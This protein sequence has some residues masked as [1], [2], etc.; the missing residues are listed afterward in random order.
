MLKDEINQNYLKARL[1]ALPHTRGDNNMLFLT[2][3]VLVAVLLSGLIGLSSYTSIANATTNTN[4]VITGDTQKYRIF[5]GQAPTMQPSDAGMATNPMPGTFEWW[6][7][8]GKFNDNST[9][10]ITLLTKP[11]V[12]K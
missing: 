8:Q 2:K 4:H 1:R 11:W 5:E 12:D 10:Q 9:E 6:Y 3:M 7:F